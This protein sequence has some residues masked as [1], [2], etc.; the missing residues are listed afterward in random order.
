MEV[1]VDKYFGNLDKAIDF[2]LESRARGEHV[3]IEFNGKELHSDNVTVDSAYME[4]LG[5]TKA[6]F[7]QQQKEILESY[8]REEEERKIREQGYAERV[9]A[10]RTEENKPITLEEVVNGLKF[11]AEH[12]S[13]SQDELIDGLLQIGCNF[14]L[15]DIKKQ[16][17]GEIGLFEG[18]K[19]GNLGAGATVVCNARDTEFGRSFCDDRFLSVDD[20][21]SLYHF[22]RIT[23]NDDTYTKENVDALNNA[24]KV[25]M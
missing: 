5:C 7:E 25:Q 24:K 23:T 12:Q 3:V 6:E 22:V 8:R 4:V 19:Q 15:D 13:M 10:S 20:D 21:M 11:I 14:T 18:I 1:K 16:F 2:L 17:P 9:K